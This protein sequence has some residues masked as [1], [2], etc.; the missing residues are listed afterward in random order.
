MTAYRTEVAN[1]TAMATDNILIVDQSGSMGFIHWRFAQFVRSLE[2][3]LQHENIGTGRL[4]NRYSLVGFGRADAPYVKVLPVNGQNF[5]LANSTPSGYALTQNS[6]TIEDGY[7]AIKVALDSLRLRPEGN[8]LAN[9]ILL[10]DEDRDVSPGYEELTRHGLKVLLKKAYGNVRKWVKLH[11]L[12]DQAYHGTSAHG[13]SWLNRNTV[14]LGP[15]WGTTK[16]DYSSVALE[17]RGTAWEIKELG[18]AQEMA[19]YAGVFAQVCKEWL[20]KSCSKCSC[21][22]NEESVCKPT[23][24][25]QCICLDTGS[26]VSTTFKHLP[27]HRPLFVVFCLPHPPP[28][29]LLCPCILLSLSLSLSLFLSLCLVRFF[30]L[31]LS[32][33]LPLPFVLS[34]FFTF[35]SS[36]LHIC[37]SA[38]VHSSFSFFSSFRP[39]FEIILAT[40]STKWRAALQFNDVWWQVKF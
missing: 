3:A 17:M 9:V 30:S 12:V 7:A 25:D 36:E 6:G 15:A 37:P 5:F 18:D 26:L 29:P 24:R 20:A 38:G 22:D 16:R 11:A 28:P 23:Y 35:C 4:P 13:L 27:R 8:V 34:I 19:S 10:T 40:N 39:Q 21:N 31:S 32:L 2:T 14:R 1:H 33:S